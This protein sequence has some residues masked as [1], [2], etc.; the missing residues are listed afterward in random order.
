MHFCI[1]D[2]IMYLVNS[3]LFIWKLKKR[4]KNQNESKLKQN[5]TTKK[6][7]INYNDNNKI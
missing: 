2:Y 7:K 3:R 6:V 1:F 4:E 5:L